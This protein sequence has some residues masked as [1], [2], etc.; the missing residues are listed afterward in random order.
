MN[1]PYRVKQWLSEQLQTKTRTQIA[2]E[3]DVSINTIGHYVRLFEL[4]EVE[5]NKRYCIGDRSK[6]F[7]NGRYKGFHRVA[8]INKKPLN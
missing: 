5:Q 2:N 7:K 1:K 3:C 8:K 4:Q 6:G